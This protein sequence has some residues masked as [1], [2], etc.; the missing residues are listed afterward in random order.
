MYRWTANHYS[1]PSCN[2]FINLEV[3]ISMMR[4][5]GCFGMRLAELWRQQNYI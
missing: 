5:K 4:W 2:S 3:K 1:F